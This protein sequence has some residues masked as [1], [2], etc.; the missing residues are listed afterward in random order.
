MTRYL[1]FFLTGFAYALLILLYS[2]LAGD[3]DLFYR[4]LGLLGAL[5]LFA[6]ASWLTLFSMRAGALVA[7]LCLFLLLCWNVVT[8]QQ[9]LQEETALD[10]AIATIHLTLGVLA[11]I[12]V[13]TSFRYIFRRGLSWR[14]GTPA[15]G[16]VLKVVLAAIPV[17][18]AVVYL[19]YA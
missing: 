2:D 11:L 8:V 15:P 13:V 7:L 3:D 6:F 1:L 18:L 19:Q 14:T 4:S 17:A 12:G 5:P 9:T 16:L 10:T